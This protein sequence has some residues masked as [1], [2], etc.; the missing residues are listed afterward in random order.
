MFTEVL[1]VTGTGG[2]G[3]AVLNRLGAG[4]NILIGD[5][6]EN[7]LAATAEHMRGRG[8][9]VTTM[10]LDVANR[11]SVRAFAEKAKGMGDVRTVVHTAGVSP[12]MGDV[13]LM[14]KVDYLGTALITE[15]FGKVIASGGAGV[16]MSSIAGY[17]VPQ[18]DAASAKAVALTP[19]DELLGLPEAT[20][21]N[22]PN[23]AAAYGFSKQANRLRIAADAQVWAKRGARLNSV[24]PGLISTP[25]G[26]KELASGG[27]GS[28]LRK[29]MSMGAIDRIG[30]PED[31]ANAVEFLV[32]PNAAYITGT[33]LLVD[34]GMVG[35]YRSGVHSL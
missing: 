3:I 23:A 27:T 28:N 32:G 24:S 14:L 19:T 13:A 8:H 31:I 17:F 18:F 12:A 7:A 6:S 10:V 30:T 20:L 26:Q 11:D 22:I 25:M 2:I 29:L 34:G 1:V 5:V 16:V 15:E 33:D 4:K 35:G 21:S 9:Q